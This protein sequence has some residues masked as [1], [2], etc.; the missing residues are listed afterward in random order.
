MHL[1]LVVLSKNVSFCLLIME[2][3]PSRLLWLPDAFDASRVFPRGW[4]GAMFGSYKLCCATIG[5][6]L[7]REEKCWVR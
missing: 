4:E 3:R 2:V 6:L 1:S 7:H 5:V